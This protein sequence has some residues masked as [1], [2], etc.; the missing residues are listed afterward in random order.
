ME[1]TVSAD[2]VRDIPDIQ[3]PNVLQGSNT[4]KGHMLPMSQ[5]PKVERGDGRHTEAHQSSSV[6]RQQELRHFHTFEVQQRDSEAR[7]DIKEEL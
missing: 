3:I 6:G 4:T 5:Q 1:A 2:T 7:K